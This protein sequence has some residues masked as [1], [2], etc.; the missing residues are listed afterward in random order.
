[1]S[2]LIETLS[3]ELLHDLNF[4]ENEN[5]DVMV[6]KVY[7]LLLKKTNKDLQQKMRETEKF[8]KLSSTR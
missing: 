2:N 1:M 6:F 7:Y 8:L 4:N 5:G 3:E